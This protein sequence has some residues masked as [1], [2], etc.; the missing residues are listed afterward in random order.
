MR[1]RLTKQNRQ[2]IL[3]GLA[4]TLVVIG[5]D[6]LGWLAPF[7][8]ILHDARFQ[9]ARQAHEPLTDRICHVDIDDASL[10]TYGRWSSWDRS[11]LAGVIEELSRAGARTIALDLILTDPQAPVFDPVGERFVD[12]DAVLAAAMRA[13]GAV[14]L[15][16]DVVG[17]AVVWS[18]WGGDTGRTERG[19]LEAV[20]RSDITITAEA[21]AERAALTGGRLADF[22]RRPMAYKEAVAGGVLASEVVDGT[23]GGRFDEFVERIA[24]SIDSMTGSFP[25]R[26]LLQ[27]AWDEAESWRS[28]RERG[29]LLAHETSGAID[30]GVPLRAFSEAA[31]AVGDV[32]VTREMDPDDAVRRIGG[33]QRTPGGVILPFSLAAACHA[34][35]IDPQSVRIEKRWIEIDGR[36]LALTD[37]AIVV[38]WPTS[39]SGWI[40]ALRQSPDDAPTAGHVSI[41]AVVSLSESRGLQQRNEAQLERLTSQIAQGLGHMLLSDAALADVREEVSVQVGS[42][43]DTPLDS[44]SKEERTSLLPYVQWDRLTQSVERGARAIERAESEL[45]ERVGGRLAFVGWTATG[46]TLA[47]VVRTPLGPNTPGVV[48]HAVVADMAMTGRVRTQL[49][50]WWGTALAGG[51]GILVTLICARFAPLGATLLS[52]GVLGAS[53]GL[54]GAWAFSRWNLIVPIAAPATAGATVWIAATALAAWQNQRERTRLTRQF[55]ARVSSELVDYLI[56]NPGA[57][58]V[59]G[60]QREMTVLFLDLAGFTAISET[61]DGHTTVATLNRFMKEMTRVLTQHG[62]Y[63]NKFLGDGLMAFWSAFQEDPEQATRA[64]RAA[65]ACHQMIE[66]LNDIPEFENTPRLSARIGITTGRVVVGDCGAPPDLNDYTVIGDSVNLAA[67]LESANKQFGS[68]A[69]IDEGTRSKLHH[70]A[71]RTRRLG[72]VAVVG[73]TK[74]VEI[75]ELIIGDVREE[76]M[77]LCAR[78]VEAFGKGEHEESARLWNEYENQFGPSKL[79]GL[80][81]RSIASGEDADGVLRLR[82]K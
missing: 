31:G 49:S 57:L 34:M 32:T 20:L 54:L 26:L 38:N 61:L 51:I 58:S 50:R 27:R 46:S 28:M 39:E 43:G 77:E 70:G 74:P 64:C 5:V 17:P 59:A 30:A 9:H 65:V 68:S 81:L 12:H 11:R 36:R 4:I 76:E 69:V 22:L 15:G 16:V 1:A 66:V 18:A 47:D 72:R 45:R 82:D 3:L 75:F 19:R 29:L 56:E 37:G 42:L 13:S 7:E 71:I 79:S 73:Q 53:G 52:F 2:T 44:L 67:R 21:A 33:F 48:V 14:V 41:G 63:V 25:E 78:A 80:Y 62:A 60:E 8:R 24:P 10:R 55:K 35:G 6:R 40:G 23:A